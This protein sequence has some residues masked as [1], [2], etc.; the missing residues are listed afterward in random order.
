MTKPPFVASGSAA[1]SSGSGVGLPM[2]HRQELESLAH[3]TAA[4]DRSLREHMSG[5]IV[6][7]R[8]NTINLGVLKLC[9]RGWT[10]SY[11]ASEALSALLED[12]PIEG[13]EWVTVN[14][15]TTLRHLLK[16]YGNRLLGYD[17]KRNEFTIELLSWDLLDTTTRTVRILVRKA[18]TPG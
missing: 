4:L 18:V 17:A 6:R 12:A 3:D 10:L 5:A 2:A 13:A 15:N 9:A 11:R 1:K 7:D 16:E 8:A 14:A